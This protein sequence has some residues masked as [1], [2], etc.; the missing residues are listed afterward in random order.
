MNPKVTLAM[1]DMNRHTAGFCLPIFTNPF[2][3]GNQ[4]PAVIEIIGELLVTPIVTSG[5]STGMRCAPLKLRS[6]F[7]FHIAID[8]TEGPLFHY[9]PVIIS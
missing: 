7:L 3:N 5:G 1:H 9:Q 2:T 4:L 6:E 8:P